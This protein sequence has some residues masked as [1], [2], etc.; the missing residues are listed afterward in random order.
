MTDK[1][2]IEQID[3]ETPDQRDEVLNRLKASVPEAFS[4][5]KL[6]VD[7]LQALLG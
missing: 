3:H 2:E 6:D 1:P 5:G 4:D 7:A